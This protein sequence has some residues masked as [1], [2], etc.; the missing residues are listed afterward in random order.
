MR[1][2]KVQCGITTRGLNLHLMSGI[3]NKWLATRQNEM[4]DTVY[5]AGHSIQTYEGMDETP[6]TTPSA[7]SYPLP[8]E[9][10]YV[11]EPMVTTPATVKTSR[12]CPLI[13]LSDIQ[14][15]DSI[16][17]PGKPYPNNTLTFQLLLG[18]LMPGHSA[19]LPFL[20]Y[21]SLRKAVER[22]HK[23]KFGRY[24]IKKLPDTNQ[25]RVWRTS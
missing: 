7:V 5:F 11:P 3:K 15:D 14:I 9:Q 13:K 20:S 16:P 23:T 17:L 18:K 2:I 6:N 25:V 8:I 12:Y 10:I 22:T 1:D 24:I 21:S 19:A 4:G